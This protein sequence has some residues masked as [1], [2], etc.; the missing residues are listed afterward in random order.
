MVP[1]LIVV[2]ME[3]GVSPAPRGTSPD[4]LKSIAGNVGRSIGPRLVQES[5]LV[6]VAGIDHVR[7]QW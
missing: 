2:A 3:V 7:I 6:V 1:S 5:W 4:T